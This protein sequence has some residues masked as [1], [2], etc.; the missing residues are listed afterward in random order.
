MLG[1]VF[2]DFFFYCFQM[3]KLVH[4]SLG[5][6][7]IFDEMEIRSLW[8]LLKNDNT[9]NSLL[10]SSGSLYMWKIHLG[11]SFLAEM[12]LYSYFL[13][14]SFLTMPS[15]LRSAPVP[16]KV[17]HP[18]N[19]MSPSPYWCSQ[20]CDLSRLSLKLSNDLY[21]QSWGRFLALKKD[22]GCSCPR[23]CPLFILHFYTT[24][25]ERRWRKCCVGSWR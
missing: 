3:E 22:C 16:P 7:Q 23:T 1:I 6:Y 19:V 12:L 2:L 11:R 25:N 14:F 9:A 20:A 10:L 24:D 15:S 13:W 18:S 8:W 21:G 4:I 5:F 17:K